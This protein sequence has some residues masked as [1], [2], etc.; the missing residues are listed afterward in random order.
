MPQQLRGS[1]TRAGER[2][3]PWGVPGSHRPRGGWPSP[4]PPQ[5]SSDAR[6]WPVPR[7]SQGGLPLSEGGPFGPPPDSG[8]LT[9]NG[10][11]QGR[12]TPTADT[13]RGFPHGD[14]GTNLEGM[15]RG[16]A[17]PGPSSDRLALDEPSGPPP[18]DPRTWPR[19]IAREVRAGPT[20]PRTNTCVGCGTHFPA[21]DSVTCE[22]CGF[23]FCS[24]CQSRERG[25]EHSPLCPICAMLLRE[26]GNA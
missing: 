4:A 11:P 21:Q 25:Q 10:V 13:Q 9:G 19:L 18:G 5:G 8:R 2:L 14:P 22:A 7:R 6:S 15:P 3:P 12:P 16:P 26:S 1:P 20:E 24:V 23:P 17:A